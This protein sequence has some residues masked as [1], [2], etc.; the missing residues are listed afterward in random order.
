MLFGVRELGLALPQTKKCPKG[1][2]WDKI[3]KECREK[4][5]GGRHK[6]SD[7]EVMYRRGSLF[8]GNRFG[9]HTPADEYAF[10]Q[11]LEQKLQNDIIGVENYPNEKYKYALL[12][13][14]YKPIIKEV[15][16]VYNELVN[17]EK[18]PIKYKNENLIPNKDELIRRINNKVLNHI[19]SFKLTYSEEGMVRD[20][21][22]ENEIELPTIVK[23][24][25][26]GEW[27]EVF[28]KLYLDKMNK[29]SNNAVKMANKNDKIKTKALIKE[30][31]FYGPV[32]FEK[33]NIT[34]ADGETIY[35]N[36]DI[37]ENKGF[38]IGGI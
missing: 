4:K 23:N 26:F 1:L 16:D 14:N 37:L 17:K 6:S 12:N 36:L 8:Y 15:L 7:L 11:V 22:Y 30:M 28:Y 24:M 3:L 20:Y 31:E 33:L 13:I 21:N 2:T 38:N 19:K 5:K 35:D 32:L 18:I 10:K 29:L 9:V 27:Y 25:A 34:S